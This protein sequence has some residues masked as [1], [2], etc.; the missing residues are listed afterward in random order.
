[1]ISFKRLSLILNVYKKGS[2]GDYCDAPPLCSANFSNPLST[3]GDR[4]VEKDRA[5]L[6]PI[7]STLSLILRNL[8]SSLAL[9]KISPV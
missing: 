2:A 4:L 1:M 6:R 3:G 5:W 7:G 9:C 8:I